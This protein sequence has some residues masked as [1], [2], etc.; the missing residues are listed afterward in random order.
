MKSIN[1][2]KGLLTAATKALPV[3]EFYRLRGEE[4]PKAGTGLTKATN[5][6]RVILKEFSSQDLALALIE[7]G[8]EKV[9]LNL[10]DISL[11]FDFDSCAHAYHPSTV[12]DYVGRRFFVADIFDRLDED[13]V[14]A[15][16]AKTGRTVLNTSLESITKELATVLRERAKGAE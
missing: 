9:L 16:V 7:R 4:P 11:H 15:W 8:E 14:V 12:L 5:G 13:E 6:K 2:I 10:V 1:I 3:E